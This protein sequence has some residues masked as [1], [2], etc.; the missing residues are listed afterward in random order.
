MPKTVDYL[1]IEEN[2]NCRV[3][4]HYANLTFT[5]DAYCCEEDAKHF[6]TNIGF[7]I[8]E[9]RALI[10]YLKYIKN[11]ELNQELKAY[12]SLYYSMKNSKHFNKK[13]YEAIMLFRKL[14]RTAQTIQDVRDEIEELQQQL[15]D[16]IN[17]I[18][19]TIERVDK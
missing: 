10:K 18:N 3:K 16:Y 19:K 9:F 14:N 17:S 1:I 12:K 6:N 7:T 4:I 2:L 8:A 15:K 5:G 13:S 11:I